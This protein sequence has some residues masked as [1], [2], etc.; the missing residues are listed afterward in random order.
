[1][2][3][4]NVKAM[5]V[6]LVTA[7]V[8]FALLK[9]MFLR[10]IDPEDFDRR[11]ILWF[12]HS[13]TAFL[14]PSIWFYLLVAVPTLLWAAK[15]DSNPI[16]LWLFVVFAVPPVSIGIPVPLITTFFGISQERL[17]GLFLLFPLMVQHLRDSTHPRTYTMK[18][19]DTLVIGYIVYQVVLALPYDSLTGNMRR[20]FTLLLDNF[21]VYFVFSRAI[22]DKRRLIDVM[23]G[24][25]LAAIVMTPL[26][27]LE[28]T[29][30]WLLYTGISEVWG[31]VNE[32]AWLFRGASLRSQ[33]STGHSIAMGYV[34]A[35][36]LAFWL[37]LRYEV[38]GARWSWAV[39]PLLCAAMFV[40][41]SRGAWVMAAMIPILTFALAP[42]RSGAEF[43]TIIVAGLVSLGVYLSPIGSRIAELLPFIGTGS[44]D[45]VDY[46]QQLAETS[47]MLVQ[48]NP[49][50]GNPFA[51]AQ[52][53][54]LRQGQ[55]IIDMVNQYAGIAVFQGLV[56]LSLFASIFVTSVFGAF[57]RMREARLEDT[58]LASAG[59][60]L[61]ACMVATLVFL[62]T[63]PGAW[64]T[65]VV[66]GILAAYTGIH[67][68]ASQSSVARSDDRHFA[69]RYAR[70]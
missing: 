29:R 68:Y 57:V 53:E 52:M 51:A 63:V 16:A 54:N 30:N 44:Q 65:W 31:S 8:M 4:L 36:A 5:I 24:L 6:V 37:Y 56:G 58:D 62:A 7:L 38:K 55:G 17:L 43:K 25:C 69:A 49:V 60:S 20:S 32:Y 33:L 15:K 19:M 59:A 2:F 66:A 61:I 67:E 3:L 12:I 13:A 47:W 21:L 28:S 11:R 26:A 18:M 23:A 1:M 45:T 70:G 42:R 9:P 50:F 27:V 41:Y 35:T 40:S 64:F 14:M 48:Q 39:V 34:M 22:T 46:R 10:F